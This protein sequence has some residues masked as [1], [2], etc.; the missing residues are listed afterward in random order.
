MEYICTEK[1]HNLLRVEKATFGQP[2]SPTKCK[3]KFFSGGGGGQG[4]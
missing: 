3:S 2:S 4:W 1:L